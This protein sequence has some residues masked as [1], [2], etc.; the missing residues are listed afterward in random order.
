MTALVW[1]LVG[2]MLGGCVSILML[3][4]MQYHRTEDYEDEIRRLQDELSKKE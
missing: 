2:L 3:C 1:L 4:C